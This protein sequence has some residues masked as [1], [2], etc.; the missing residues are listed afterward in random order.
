MWQKIANIIL[1]NRFFILGV[2]TLTTVFLTYYAATG[3]KLENKYGIVL[4]KD[5]PTTR[6][7][8][9]FKTLFGEDGGTLA[10]AIKTDSLYTEKNFAKWKELGDSI[11]K[12]DGVQSIISEATLFTIHNNIEDSKFEVKRIFSDQTFKEKSIDSIEREIKT[13]PIYKGLLYNDKTNVSLMLIGVDERFVGDQ[14]KSKVILEIEELAK[15]YETHFKE[16]HFAG[17][18]HLRV[19]IAKRIQQDMFLF[20]TI[21]MVITALVLYGFFRSFRATF[22]CLLVI[23]ISVVWSLGT[24]AF[25]GFRLSVL[26]ALI[27]PL[28]IVIAVPNCVYLITKFHQEVKIHGNKI[29]ALTR[30]IHKIGMAI[31]MTNVMNA[32]GFFTFCFTNSEKLMEFGVI[33]S[34]NVMLIFLISLTLLPIFL[35]FSKAPKAKHLKHLDR[36]TATGMMSGIERWVITK[37]PLIYTVT[38]VAI[39]LSVFGAMRVETTGNITSDL[40]QSDPIYKDLKFFEKHFGGSIPF[41][42]MIG[43]KE[44][45]RL[46]KKA[47]LEKLE[48]IQN[49]YAQDT[50]FSKSISIVDFLKAINMAYYGNDPS[51]YALFSNR[52]RLR[53]KQYLDNFDM[54]NLNGGISVKELL[55]TTSCT[56]RVRSQMKDMGAK[57]VGFKIDHIR[58]RVDSILNPDKKD[59]ER[60]YAK[61]TAGKKGYI[62][63]IV[64]NYPAIYNSLTKEISGKNEDLQFKFDSDPELLKTY[65]K[66]SDFNDKLR[67]AI[68]H[69]YYDLTITGTSVVASEGTKYLVDNLFS[70]II[71]AILCISILMALLFR[72]WRMVVV[73]M[74]PNLIPLIVTAGVMGILGIPLKPSTLLVFNIALGISV[75]DAIH[76]L[77]KYRQELKSKKWD[78]QECVMIAIRDTG[79]GRYYTSIVLFCGFSVFLFSQFG[80]TQALGILVSLTLF[81]AMITNFLILPTLLLSLNKRLLSKSFEEPYFE[82]YSEESEIDWTDLKFSD[83]GDHDQEEPKKIDS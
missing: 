31:F 53:L 6:N 50:S 37:R 52:D 24:M 8:S 40:P 82:A 59:I 1:K 14:K 26:M 66:K 76:F 16:M 61:V 44:K 4:P 54:T 12:I 80:G 9:L 5:S 28:M 22:I 57:E 11:L 71:F 18:P 10:I 62:D 25:I 63:S 75:D 2:I 33:A 67:A 32:I 79:L 13:S 64:E 47:T 27:P 43:Y 77:E 42:M 38:I 17:L 68:D 56:V 74:I 78:L 3:L 58:H 72:S 45:G 39:V 83:E 20:I 51:K 46:F 29:K 81:V 48:A 69:E 36:K 21:S 7:Y 65:Y 19:I 30:V 41:E 34:I 49:E 23:A 15:T 70:G 60:L 35:S 55:D 73:A